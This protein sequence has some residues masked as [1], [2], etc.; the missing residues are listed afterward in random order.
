M[1]KRLYK[2]G[3]EAEVVGCAADSVDLYQFMSKRCEAV[4]NSYHQKYTIVMNVTHTGIKQ[5]IELFCINS[6]GNSRRNGYGRGIQDGDWDIAE[7][8]VSRGNE[9]I[10]IFKKRIE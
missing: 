1:I 3:Y 2:L 5:N 9:T 8:F 4:F 6:L 10:M 7:K